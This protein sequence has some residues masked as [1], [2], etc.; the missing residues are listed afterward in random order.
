MKTKYSTLLPL[1]AAAAVAGCGTETA[2][3]TVSFS[4][5]VKP[6]I[7]QKCNECHKPGGK[8]VEKS[9]LVMVDYASLMKGTRFG[10]VVEPGSA[11]S[12]TMYLAVAGKTDPQIRMPHGK[13]ILNEQQVET[14]KNWIDQGAKNN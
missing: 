9:G 2:T 13:D 5:D 3:P 10:P 14:I 7:E 4:A 12:S 11:I 6:I 1:L 8:G